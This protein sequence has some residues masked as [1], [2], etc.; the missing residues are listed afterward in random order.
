MSV[1]EVLPLVLLFVAVVALLAVSLGVFNV[2]RPLQELDRRATRVA[3][4]DFDAVAQPVGGVQ[5]ID[6]LRAT[7]TARLP[8]LR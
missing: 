7:I 3:W 2:I 6:D 1:V 4:G 5:E 8:L